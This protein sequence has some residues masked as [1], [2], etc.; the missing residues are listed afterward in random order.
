MNRTA[1]Q[2]TRAIEWRL[3]PRS[4]GVLAGTVYVE[5]LG[6]RAI[7]SRDMGLWH[8][9]VSHPKRYPTWDEI[10]DARERFIPDDVTMAMLLPPKAEYVNL[11]ETTMQLWQVKPESIGGTA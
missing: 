1:V 11:H 2:S 3:A 4:G 8:L 7:V 10:A 5:P 6:L 9:S